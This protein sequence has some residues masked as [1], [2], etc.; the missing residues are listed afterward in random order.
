[1]TRVRGHEMAGLEAG[2]GEGEGGGQG[3]GAAVRVPL[4]YP[5]RSTSGHWHHSSPSEV[6]AGLASQFE[7]GRMACWVTQGGWGH[8]PIP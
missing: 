8:R 5:P 3:R 6:R 4:S 2:G 1:M 7:G